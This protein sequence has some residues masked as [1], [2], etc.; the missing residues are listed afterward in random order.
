MV[1]EL[2]WM[3]LLDCLDSYYYGGEKRVRKMVA[4]SSSSS[5]ALRLRFEKCMMRDDARRSPL[6]VLPL[7]PPAIVFRLPPEEEV[8]LAAGW[9]YSDVLVLE[10][11]NCNG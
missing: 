5:F 10:H 3:C 1:I 8:L 11:W 2:D 6:I 7:R 9:P 4:W